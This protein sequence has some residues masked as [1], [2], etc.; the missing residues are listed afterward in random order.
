MW[1]HEA[2]PANP[3][4]RLASSTL[5]LPLSPIVQYSSGQLFQ[6]DGGPLN[7]A[8]YAVSAATG[9]EGLCGRVLRVVVPT[10]SC[11]G[12]CHTAHYATVSALFPAAVFCLCVVQPGHLRFLVHTAAAQ[13]H[14]H[15]GS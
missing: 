4:Y 8:F 11:K 14:T 13:H 10:A 7:M 9:N 1:I 2:T 3:L 5:G 15:A 12:M 6:P